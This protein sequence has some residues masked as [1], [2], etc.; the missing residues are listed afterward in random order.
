MQ[1]RSRNSAT[2]IGTEKH[3]ITLTGMQGIEW[4][5]EGVQGA[6]EGEMRSTR[7]LHRKLCHVIIQI[8]IKVD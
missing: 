8:R 7:F 4:N 2:G 6:C 3:C 5:L 1:L